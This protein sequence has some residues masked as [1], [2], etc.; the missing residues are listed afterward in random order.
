MSANHVSLGGFNRVATTSSFF[1]LGWWLF[2]SSI[3]FFSYRMLLVREEIEP[4]FNRSL[5]P[6]TNKTLIGC[7][8]L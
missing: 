8:D 4:P 7:F 6:A 1:R 5:V 3:A 2:W